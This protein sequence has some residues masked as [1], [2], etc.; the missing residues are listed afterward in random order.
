MNTKILT[1]TL[2]GAVPNNLPDMV[3]DEKRTITLKCSPIV[4]SSSVSAASFSAEPDNLT[5]GSA[6]ISGNNATISVT[7][8]EAGCYVI[9]ASATLANGEIYKGITNL[10]VIDP[11]PDTSDY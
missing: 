11:S 3:L 9:T 7:A 4:G 8:S 5:I 10:K 2:S 1:L 6:S